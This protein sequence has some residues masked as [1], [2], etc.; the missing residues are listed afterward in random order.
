MESLKELRKICQVK[1]APEHISMRFW[2]TFSIYFTKIFIIFGITPNIINWAGF[3]L[4]LAGGILFLKQKFLI[5][6]ILYI[7]VYIFDDV[8]GELA[9]YY[10]KASKYGWWQDTMVGHLLYPYFFLMLGLGIFFQ[11][12]NYLYLL[13]GAIA[14]IAKMIERSVP[15]VRG[16]TDNDKLLKTKDASMKKGFLGDVKEWL[17]HFAKTVFIYPLAVIF[18]S[19][20]NIEYILWIYVPYLTLFALAKVV[21]TGWRVYIFDKK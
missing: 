1:S 14:A 6:S 12:E 15:E 20:G 11:T 8:D 9:R 2:R 5:G 21:L 19:L 4:G 18:A 7:F 17:A 3:A 13:L 16:I 10:K